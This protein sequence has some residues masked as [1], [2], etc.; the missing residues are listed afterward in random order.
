MAVRD[1]TGRTRKTKKA[2]PP[3]APAATNPA[4]IGALVGSNIESAR[5]LLATIYEAEMRMPG[6]GHVGLV[7]EHV[8]R[9]C[10]QF[11]RDAL[12]LIDPDM[13]QS[14]VLGDCSAEV[15]HG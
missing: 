9:A 14:P 11:L 12:M 15:S 3:A 13:E 2:A 10:D 7:V 1:S 8:G 5:M 6:T 4:D